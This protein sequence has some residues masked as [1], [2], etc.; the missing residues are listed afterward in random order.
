V[1]PDSLTQLAYGPGGPAYFVG[2]FGSLDGAGDATALVNVPA[3]SA[4]SG[5]TV[6]FAY[7]LAFPAFDF[8][9]PARGVDLLP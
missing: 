2:L 6:H 1:N 7:F 4:M 5:F 9:S 8:V 3:L